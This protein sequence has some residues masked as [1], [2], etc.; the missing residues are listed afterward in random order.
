VTVAPEM[1]ASVA[2]VAAALRGA[3]RVSAICHENPDADTVGAAL[4]VSIM[5]ER[6][7]AASEVVCADPMPPQFDF[8][9]RIDHVVR[10][11]QL[12]PGLA[13]VCD[14]A[15]LERVGRTVIEES[16]WL[17]RATIVN[18]DHHVTNTRFGGIN[19]VDPHAA[20]TCEVLTSLAL[21]LGLEL[22]VELATPLLTGIVRDTHGFADA[23]TSGA[24]LRMAATLLDA[25]APLAR[26]HRSILTELPY[27]TLSLWGRMLRGI[28]ERMDGRIVYATLTQRMLDETGT[29]QH[30]ADGVVELMANTKGAAIA[31]LL[32]EI[33][34]R[35]TR[36]SLRTT[37][38]ADATEIA[39]AFGGGGHARRAGCTVPQPLDAAVDLMLVASREALSSE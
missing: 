30:D 6:L 3:S 17:A 18:I 28:G 13:I 22:D 23:A 8:L 25:G 12:E 20:A 24:T 31:M 38:A 27:P 26:V 9:P 21:E 29:Q 4:A 11:P 35:E 33:G 36:V 34:P 10:R 32:R 15:T 14:A 37:D 7:G 5:A 1:A 2:D 39:A 19:L 16:D